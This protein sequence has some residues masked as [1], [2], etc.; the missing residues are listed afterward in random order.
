VIGLEID[1]RAGGFFKTRSRLLTA[2]LTQHGPT[3]LIA[4]ADVAACAVHHRR[5]PPRFILSPK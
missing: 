3:H 5:Y 1:G 2:K 4:R